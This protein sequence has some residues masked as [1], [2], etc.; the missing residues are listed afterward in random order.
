MTVAFALLTSFICQDIIHPNRLDDVEFRAELGREQRIT[1]VKEPWKKYLSEDEGSSWW[2]K[3]QTLYV[4]RCM[5]L[6]DSESICWGNVVKERSFQKGCCP[7]F[8]SPD[9]RIQWEGRPPLAWTTI[10]CFLVDWRG[11]PAFLPLITCER[12]MRRSDLD[13]PFPIVPW[14]MNCRV[15]PVMLKCSCRLVGAICSNSPTSGWKFCCQLLDHD[16]LDYEVSHTTTVS[17][18]YSLGNMRMTKEINSNNRLTTT[19]IPSRSVPPQTWGASLRLLLDHMVMT[20]EQ[21]TPHLL[22]GKK[23]IHLHARL[24]CVSDALDQY[25]QIKFLDI[26]TSLGLPWRHS[27]A[28]TDTTMFAWILHHHV[29]CSLAQKYHDIMS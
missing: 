12:M 15:I 22:C 1:N 4:H 29:E 24:I 28:T 14:S 25:N 11:L 13:G 6:I 9:P 27:P 5:S 19:N 2:V 26:L 21:Y 20:L 17:P 8:G 23:R 16:P 10:F 7:G 3:D 18:H